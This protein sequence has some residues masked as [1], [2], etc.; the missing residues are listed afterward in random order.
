MLK[1]RFGLLAAG[2]GGSLWC[3]VADEV[4]DWVP[5]LDCF[6]G[7][8]HATGR[9]TATE[10]KCSMVRWLGVPEGDIFGSLL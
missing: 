9:G 1:G 6:C 4:A 10:G 3:C 7:L 8:P 2:R 5:D